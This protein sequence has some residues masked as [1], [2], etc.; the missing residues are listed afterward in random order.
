MVIFFHGTR[1]LAY[2][3]IPELEILKSR[4]VGKEFE[5]VSIFERV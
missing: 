5:N 2:P 3:V 1:S 4:E